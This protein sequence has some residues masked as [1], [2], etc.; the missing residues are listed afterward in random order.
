MAIF[1]WDTPKQA[2]L[3]TRSARRKH[4]IGSAIYLLEPQHKSADRR[5][6]WSGAQG[7]I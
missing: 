4:L 1:G 3:Y 7:R 6:I 5:P 2:A